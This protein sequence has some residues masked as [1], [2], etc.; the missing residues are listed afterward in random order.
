MA[1]D[2]MFTWEKFTDTKLFLATGDADE[3]KVCRVN[4]KGEVQIMKYVLDDEPY[5][6]CDIT[7]CDH[8]ICS[9]FT[10]K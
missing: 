8:M 5:F 2:Q 10:V 6:D 9:G 3:E 1:T 7:H 4:S